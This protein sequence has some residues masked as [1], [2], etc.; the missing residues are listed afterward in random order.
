MILWLFYFITALWSYPKFLNKKE[1]VTRKTD[2][3]IPEGGREHIEKLLQVFQ[4][5]YSNNILFLSLDCSVSFSDADFF[6][7][8]QQQVSDWVLREET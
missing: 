1:Q 7:F 8:D 3:P 5:I 6:T 2:P 4:R